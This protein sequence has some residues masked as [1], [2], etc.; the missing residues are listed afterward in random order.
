MIPSIFKISKTCPLPKIDKVTSLDDLRPIAITPVL[1]QHFERLIYD[2]FILRKY[3]SWLPADQYGFRRNSSTQDVLICLKHTCK[4]FDEVG[5]DYVRI[6]S[7]HLSEA[8]DRAPRKL[9]IKK[10]F[11]IPSV[12]PFIVNILTNFL[13]GRQQY[14]AKDNEVSQMRTTNNGVLQGTVLGPP[15]YNA[16]Y[17]DQV[18]EAE[19]YV[20]V[21]FIDDNKQC[22]GGKNNSDKPQAVIRQISNG[23]V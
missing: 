8:F 19:G 1:A 21:K 9:I 17:S 7:L 3:N 6:F 18:V 2:R 10:V 20:P 13:T 15:Y 23:A 16:A 11:E 14:A 12:D 5:C 22:V 4:A